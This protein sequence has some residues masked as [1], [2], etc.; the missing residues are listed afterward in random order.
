MG[1]ASDFS[2][3]SIKLI[4]AA[5]VEV[6]PLKG[7]VIIAID[8]QYQSLFLNSNTYI[9]DF[10]VYLPYVEAHPEAFT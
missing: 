1:M 8:R 2:H 3:S 5:I 9:L 10:K 6:R 7:E 4:L